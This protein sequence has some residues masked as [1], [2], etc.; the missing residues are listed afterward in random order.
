MPIVKSLTKGT[1]QMSYFIWQ[2]PLL[3]DNTISFSRLGQMFSNQRF[4]AP[5][6]ALE[7]F[8]NTTE[9]MLLA[10]MHRHGDL[11]SPGHPILF[12]S[13]FEKEVWLEIIGR[14]HQV[15]PLWPTR[16]QFRPPSSGFLP[17]SFPAPPHE[18]DISL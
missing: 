16:D 17:V 11:Q 5:V 6:D 13:I 18:G 15:F 14:G 10:R 4:P 9:E 7:L 12:P 3:Y 1:L 8:F 2:A